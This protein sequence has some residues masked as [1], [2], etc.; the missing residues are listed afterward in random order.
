MKI[1]D[2]NNMSSEDFI[3]NFKNIFEKTSS[4]AFFSEKKRPYKDKKHLIK[5]FI[6]EFES[7][8][9]SKK[10]TIINNHPDLGNKLKI[11][12]TLT[13]MSKNEQKNAGLDS[14]TKEEFLLFKRMNDEYKLKFSIPFIFAVKGTNKS[15]IID[16]FKR[17]LKNE[18][19]DLEIAE[20]IKQV[21]KIAKFRLEEI[22]HE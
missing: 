1:Q 11:I 22:I 13:D 15:I 3:E 18:D 8:S 6:D 4:I 9:I 19:I 5:V 12:N 10:K 2:V 21:K 14:C 17:R 16:E 7:L 20:S